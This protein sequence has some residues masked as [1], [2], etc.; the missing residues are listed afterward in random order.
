MLFVTGSPETPLAPDA[1][2]TS[3]DE[4]SLAEL[5][6]TAAPAMSKKTLP[7]MMTAMSTLLLATLFSISDPF[8]PLMTHSALDAPRR[9]P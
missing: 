8:L 9:N 1:V 2:F 4:L 6:A 7:T 3:W 5:A